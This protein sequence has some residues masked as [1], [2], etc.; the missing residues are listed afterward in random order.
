MDPKGPHEGCSMT[1]SRRRAPAPVPDQ[2]GSLAS[3][4]DVYQVVVIP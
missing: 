1:G 3:V 4:V 2:F